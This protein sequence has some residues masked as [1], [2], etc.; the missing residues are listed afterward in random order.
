LPSVLI[1]YPFAHSHQKANADVLKKA[2]VAVVLEQKDMNRQTLIDAVKQMVKQGITPAV[3]R[4]KL[5]GCFVKDPA[6]QLVRSILS[7]KS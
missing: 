3:A 5:E 6:Q 7:I 4:Q 2:G 1:P